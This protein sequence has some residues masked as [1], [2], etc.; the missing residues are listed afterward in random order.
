MESLFLKHC[1]AYFHQVE[2]KAVF[3]DWCY[4]HTKSGVVIQP[5]T[6]CSK[7]HCLNYTCPAA[8][9][10]RTYESLTPVQ[11][12]CT[13]NNNVCLHAPPPH[14]FN[15]KIPTLSDM[16]SLCSPKTFATIQKQKCHNLKD[17]NGTLAGLWRKCVTAIGQLL[18]QVQS[19]INNPTLVCTLLP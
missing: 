16:H 2:R 4:T 18:S 1:Y 7:Y 10:V 13:C 19:S 5:H 17:T 11:Y 15:G 9:K 8:K 6:L 14:T 3:F 12:W